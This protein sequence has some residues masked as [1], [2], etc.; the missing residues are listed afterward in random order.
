MCQQFSKV[1]DEGGE[2]R[3]NTAT[4]QGNECSKVKDYFI[5]QC[6]I[7]E[8]SVRIGNIVVRTT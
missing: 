1:L 3:Y 6:F 8:D 4:E 5:L 7:T 2:L